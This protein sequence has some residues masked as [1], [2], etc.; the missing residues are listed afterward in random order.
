MSIS[1]EVLAHILFK[2]T[3]GKGSTNNDREFF[4]EP[5]NGKTSISTDQIWTE[6]NLIPPVAPALSNNQINGIIQF[7]KDVLLTAVPGTQSS[8]QSNDLIDVIPFNFD[9]NG[10]YNYILKD[11][12][13][14][15]IFFGFKD[16]IV[17]GD[18]GILT[19][20]KDIPSNM[21]PKISFYKYIGTKGDFASFSSNESILDKKVNPTKVT[22]IGSQ[23]TGI[24]ISSDPIENSLVE[25]VVN[26]IS[27]LVGD[28]II[29]K[30]C[31][32][33]DINGNIKGYQKSNNMDI[34]IGDELYWNSSSTGF[35]LDQNDLVSIYYSE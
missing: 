24:F 19:F 17:D 10:S 28:G 32:F 1:P 18:T 15:L 34:K 31:Y 22:S 5:F 11:S 7:K 33:K 29:T 9:P 12:N 26:G 14:A 16:W 2:K 3:L 35:E 20:Y 6:S 4:E 27:Y 23:N 25:V 21:P 8:F 30:D 13:N